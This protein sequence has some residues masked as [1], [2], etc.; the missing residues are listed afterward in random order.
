MILVSSCLGGINCKYSGENNINMFVLQLINSGQAIP[1]CA[2]QLGG[3]PTPRIPAEIVGNRVINKNG[4]DVTLEFEMG[5]KN[6]LA[7]CKALNIKV[8]ILKSKSPSCGCGKVYDGSFCGKL[9][10]GNGITA[11]LLSDNGIKVFSENQLDKFLDYKATE[12]VG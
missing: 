3:L 7:V 9:V 12:S 10:D 5:A 8:A 4:E 2:E 11:K 1:L 6:V